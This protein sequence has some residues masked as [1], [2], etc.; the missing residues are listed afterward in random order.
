M[1]TLQ[2]TLALLKPDLVAIPV[3]AAE[4]HKIILRNGFY[5][6]KSKELMLSRSDAERFYQEHKGKFFYGRLVNYMSSGP[7]SAHILAHHD[8]IL[9]WRNIMG[10]T[11]VFK[12]VFE[13]PNSIRGR[14]GLTDTR[15]CT[16]GSDSDETA[17]REIYFYF[18]EFNVHKWMTTEEEFFRKGHVTFNS[19]QL[20]HTT[21]HNQKECNLNNSSDPS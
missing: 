10:P 21:I 11:K 19:E 16:H 9:K 5:F 13:A 1:R 6:V 14:F 17:A 15:N 3:N 8:A 20:E 12:T 18:P 7:L 4:V 2:L